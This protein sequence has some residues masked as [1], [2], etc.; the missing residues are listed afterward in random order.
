[1]AELIEAGKQGSGPIAA[2]DRRLAFDGWHLFF[3][4]DFCAGLRFPEETGQ[5]AMQHGPDAFPAEVVPPICSHHGMRSS[6]NA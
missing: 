3:G 1:M 4:V 5:A 2:M 6:E